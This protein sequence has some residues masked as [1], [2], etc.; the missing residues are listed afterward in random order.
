MPGD[1]NWWVAPVLSAAGGAFGAL[2]AGFKS[3]DYKRHRDARAL[4]AGL[5]GELASHKEGWPLSL[6]ALDTIEANANAGTLVRIPK[7]DRPT[8]RFFDQNVGK[9]GLLGPELVEA[10]VYIYNNITAFRT[11]FLLVSQE[12]LDAQQHASIARAARASIQRAV[13][14]FEEVAPKLR[15][16]AERPYAWFKDSGRP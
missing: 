16:L 1:S 7:I 12:D 4:A 14:R 6:K 10:V 13:S 15:A 2:I 3:E 9:L 5:L 8:D 11:V